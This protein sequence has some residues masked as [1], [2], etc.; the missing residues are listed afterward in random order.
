M[1]TVMKH[2]NLDTRDEVIRQFVL[3]LAVEREGSVLEL[4][5][6]AVVC[7][8]PVQPEKGNGQ[9]EDWTEEKNARRCALI[10]REIAGSLTLEEAKELQGLQQAMLRYR[11]RIAPL[12]LDDAD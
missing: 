2:V 5:G 10:D 11:R 4:N 7:V 1:G 9:E 6:Q 12:P 8:L 3:T